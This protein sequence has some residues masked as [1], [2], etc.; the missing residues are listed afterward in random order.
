MAVVQQ[1]LQQQQL[2]Q[3]QQM[4]QAYAMGFVVEE[5]DVE[6][7]DDENKEDETEEEEEE[8]E[9][10]N[11]EGGGGEGEDDDDDKKGKRKGS[12]LKRKKKKKKKKKKESDEG[13][14][15][16]N[17][18]ESDHVTRFRSFFKPPRVIMKALEE[19]QAVIPLDVV[20]PSDSEE[21]AELYL[22]EE[23][24]RL[25]PSEGINVH[26]LERDRLRMYNARGGMVGEKPYYDEDG[27]GEG[28]GGKNKKKKKK[29]RKG[30]K[31][32][33][34]ESVEIEV[35]R[36]KEKEVEQQVDEEE[37]QEEERGG[38]EGK[39]IQQII[40]TV[41]DDVDS[42]LG[43]A[44]SN[45][46][47]SRSSKRTEQSHKKAK[48]EAGSQ[49]RRAGNIVSSSDYSE[50]EERKENEIDKDVKGNKNS[51]RRI[52][53]SPRQK[54]KDKGKKENDKLEHVGE[55]VSKT[56][57]VRTTV[58]DEV[59][60]QKPKSGKTKPMTKQDVEVL[61]RAVVKYG[62]RN[63]EVA[64]KDELFRD[65]FKDKTIKQLDKKL[66]NMIFLRQVHAQ[67][68]LNLYDEMNPKIE[69]SRKPF[70][71]T[72]AGR[73]S[74][75]PKTRTSVKPF[76]TTED[77]GIFDALYRYGINQWSAVLKDPAF[78]DT[79]SP[80]RTERDLLK[81]QFEL[82]CENKIPQ[83][84]AVAMATN[85]YQKEF[86]PIMD[87]TSTVKGASGGL[88]EVAEDSDS[89]SADDEPLLN[90]VRSLDSIPP[91]SL[92]NSRPPSRQQKY[93][94]GERASNPAP[95]KG[96]AES[97]V[98]KGKRKRVAEADDSVSA[99]GA[100]KE[101]MSSLRGRAPTLTQKKK[102]PTKNGNIGDTK[103]SS[104]S[105][106]DD[107]YDQPLGSRV[108]SKTSL[109]SS[110][111]NV[112]TSTV[113]SS[114]QTLRDIHKRTKHLMDLLA[115]SSVRNSSN[116]SA[117]CSLSASTQIPKEQTAPSQEA[118]KTPAE[119]LP[120]HTMGVN[121]SLNVGK[122]EVKSHS[123]KFKNSGTPSLPT[124]RHSR[125]SRSPPKL[126][127]AFQK[128]RESYMRGVQSTSSMAQKKDA[129]VSDLEK[130]QH[131]VVVNQSDVAEKFQNV[132]KLNKSS[133]EGGFADD[134]V[135][136]IVSERKLTVK[137]RLCEPER[138]LNV[139]N[140]FV[141]EDIES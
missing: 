24:G 7:V 82:M 123:D 16:T 139:H 89:L 119:A 87:C 130:V 101:G 93:S 64:L 31:E 128:V 19:L 28:D 9:E 141:L 137:E 98:S 96:S 41:D 118:E 125:E 51:N 129:L 68:L 109:R 120:A 134:S 115:K 78:R 1:Q 4:Q 108:S 83:T 34:T 44:S 37:E 6:E 105:S 63:F 73:H 140:L 116:A 74:A 102:L 79:F 32:R 88:V 12:A 92:N 133:D 85:H 106:D 52:R 49:K 94:K 2:Q 71:R 62:S 67:E 53:Q 95:L 21:E 5:T 8:E 50:E 45:N 26:R 57:E 136:R 17:G 107:V 56:N 114:G 124:T 90:R 126:R 46:G 11:E 65:V 61:L 22:V 27:D 14:I 131:A 33:E 18:V 113:D 15:I 138:K 77:Q 48:R 97:K 80:E 117:N 35:G 40:S 99:K 132:S 43:D 135:A 112:S 60:N 39:Q 58:I 20:P 47:E 104:S 38:K 55:E 81:R 111:E 110:S 13:L 54:A 72:R 36:E 30:T 3:Q 10:E 127:N 76:S 84:S 100:R 59:P 69:L 103:S 91:L 122:S 121:N 29:L 23:D 75:A 66:E 25:V 42:N 70:G 86:K